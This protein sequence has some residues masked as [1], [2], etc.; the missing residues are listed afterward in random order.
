MNL[1][2]MVANLVQQVERRFYGKYRGIV[3]DNEDPEQLGRLRVR[4]PS[5]LG[6]TVVTGWAL[7]CVP[8]GGQANQGLLCIPA[9]G[10]GVWVEFEAGDLEFPVWTGMFWSKPDGSSEL[11]KPNNADGSEQASVQDPPTRKILKTSKGHTI[12]FEDADGQEML[13]IIEATH[14]RMIALDADGIRIT[15]G[16]GQEITFHIS[17]LTIT[18]MHGNSVVMGPQGIRLGSDQA[19]EPFVLGNQFLASVNAFL[20]ALAAHTHTSAA[21]GSPTSSSVQPMQLQVPLSA[22][23]KVE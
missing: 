1:E 5:V 14:R 18:D 10:S 9:R 15:D 23:H 8:F 16:S 7:P 2:R 20:T 3:E 22:K 11:P 19:A 13:T 12:Q 4:V 21:P 17:G 6:T